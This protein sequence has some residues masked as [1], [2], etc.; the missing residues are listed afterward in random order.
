MSVGGEGAG[1]IGGLRR[2]IK[3]NSDYKRKHGA[4]AFL[5]IAESF[6]GYSNDVMFPKKSQEEPDIPPA[7]AVTETPS[8]TLSH[9]G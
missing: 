9:G 6:I 4:R 7:T 3:L 5:Q 1:R 8:I 2:H